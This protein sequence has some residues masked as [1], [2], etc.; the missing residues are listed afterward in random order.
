MITI[1][2]IENG[3][4]IGGLFE[5]DIHYDTLEHAVKNDS[6][7]RAAILEA[8]KPE[9][10]ER[11]DGVSEY[12]AESKWPTALATKAE[13]E[14]RIEELEMGISELQMESYKPCT[15]V[16]GPME[17][18]GDGE[19]RDIYISVN[20]DIDVIIF[21]KGSEELGFARIRPENLKVAE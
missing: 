17:K 15:C 10:E 11:G 14:K 7:L 8:M 19:A 3:V 1:R 16:A 20:D 21:N 4:V 12:I 9:R 6:I 18:M 5:K 13:L 2:E